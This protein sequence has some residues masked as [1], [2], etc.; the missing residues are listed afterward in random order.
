MTTTQAT[1]ARCGEGT[2]GRGELCQRCARQAQSQRQ[3]HAKAPTDAQRAAWGMSSARFASKDG[4]KR[5]ACPVGGAHHWILA[6]QRADT[7][8]TCKKCDATR[9]FT[10]NAITSEHIAVRRPPSWTE[11]L[12]VVNGMYG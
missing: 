10:P 7:S 11:P 5:E 12:A 9:Q 4:T 6:D 1:C 2:A 3:K 8:G